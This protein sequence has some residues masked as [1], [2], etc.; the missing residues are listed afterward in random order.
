MR[1]DILIGIGRGILIIRSIL[2]LNRCIEITLYFNVAFLG[3]KHIL[4]SNVI[5]LVSVYF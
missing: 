1:T 4:F 3:F 2:H 5:D